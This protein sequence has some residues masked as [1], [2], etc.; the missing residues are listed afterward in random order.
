MT[1]YAK[2]SMVVVLGVVV[3]ISVTIS[4]H[5][6]GNRR[7]E[8]RPEASADANAATL[9]RM[10]AEI[11]RLSVA[12]RRQST[13]IQSRSPSDASAG[14]GKEASAD[15]RED[16]PVPTFEERQ[17]AQHERL[18]RREQSLLT[19]MRT[20][21]R[22]E[23]WATETEQAIQSRVGALDP[24]TFTTTRLRSVTCRESICEARISHESSEEAREIA[25]GMSRIPS[26]G[27]LFSMRE[28][29]AVEGSYETAIFFG[30]DGH[31]LPQ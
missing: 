30:R 12:V 25:E 20:Q 31:I 21:Q 26:I 14:T 23:V 27:S 1:I 10:Q 2:A 8:A 6:S 29:G 28:D 3:A 5:L 11:N 16:T 24:Q 7:T 4:R 15:Q 9:K 13:Q 19:T 18:K 17:A 22:D